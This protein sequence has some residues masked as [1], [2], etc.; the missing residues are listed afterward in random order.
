MASL[1]MGS[2]GAANIVQVGGLNNSKRGSV[3]TAGDW[4]RHAD[5]LTTQRAKYPHVLLIERGLTP[6]GIATYAEK[7]S[8][9]R[10]VREIYTRPDRVTTGRLR[11]PGYQRL[12][13]PRPMSVA[14]YPAPNP[15]SIFTTVTF[16]EHA[17][18][19][20][21]SAVTPSKAAP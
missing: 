11:L 15:L 6:V 21:S 5:P 4:S 14:R 8:G 10:S 1:S 2:L 13:G 18:S 16:G 7:I 3:A 20:P 12:R 19:I 9:E 17:F